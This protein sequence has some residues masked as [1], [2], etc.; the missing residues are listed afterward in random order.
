MAIKTSI[1]VNDGMSPALK[2]MNRALNI[3]LNSFESVQMASSKAIDT[4]SMK[5]A[6]QELSNANMILN[7]TEQQMRRINE[8]ADKMPE[9]INKTSN[10]AGNM[11]SSLKRLAL[12]I[13]SVIGIEKLLGLSDEMANTKARLNLIVDDGGSVQ[14]LENK[15]FESANRARANYMDMASSVA[16][17][18]MNAGK[19]FSNN[20]ETIAFAE[21]M[22]KQFAIAGA[23]QQ[24][25]ASATLQL[26]QALGSGVLRG[27]ELNAVFEA[28][29][30]IIQTIADYLDVDIG[31]IRKMASEGEITADIVKNAMFSATDEINEK[32]NN[33]PMTWSQIGTQIQNYAIKAFE[34]MLQKINEIANSDRFKTFLNNL[35]AGL[36][37]IA[38]IA[39]G[40]F[41]I[42]MTGVN[43]I[44]DN[45]DIISAVLAGIVAGFVAWNAITIAQTIAQWA[46]NAAILAN[47]LTWI[48]VGIGLVIG[49]I[50][51]WINKMGGLKVAWL[52]V[53]DFI[54]YWWNVLQI[55]FMTGVFKVMNFL[56]TLALGWKTVGVAIANFMGD[57]KVKVLTI[58]QNLVN[59]AIDIINGFIG[60]LNNIPRC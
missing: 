59:G 21:L 60:L 2:S 8:E 17:L 24:E 12:G 35:S 41:N 37:E 10:S 3:M 23:G 52:T 5:I 44:A 1:I 13:G 31:Q 49:A 57:M 4:T 29:P 50:V 51:L 40:T 39:M 58:L 43:W 54:Q 9:K 46:L 14:E 45:W 33:M 53:V 55:G 30:P 27:E 42:I 22:N 47:P 48:I 15:I 7:Q 34:P 38:N 19:A 56:D 32:F 26:T 20:D 25:V 6:R 11:L 16:K 18:S 28:A 36:N